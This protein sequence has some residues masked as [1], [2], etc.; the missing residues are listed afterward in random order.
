MVGW[1]LSA[2]TALSSRNFPKNPASGGNPASETM[3]RVMVVAN[4][5]ERWF[6]PARAGNILVV[7][8]PHDQGDDRERSRRR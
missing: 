5:G 7:Q 8:M 6:N 2:M 3:A 1:R 4:S